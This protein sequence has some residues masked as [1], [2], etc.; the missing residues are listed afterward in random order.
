MGAD[1]T[2]G[3]IIKAKDFASAELGKL[4]GELGKVEDKSKGAGKGLAGLSP[5]AAGVVAGGVTLLVGGLLK[6]GQ[7]AVDEQVNIAKLD[8]A[9]KTNVKGWKGNTDA[10]EAQIS[11][12]E[13]LAFSDDELRS[14]LAK[15]VTI[16]GDV[17]RAQEMQALAMDL[18]RA[19]GIDLATATDAIGK[20]SQGSTRP[21][22][23]LG[24]EIDDSRTAAENLAALQEKVAGQAGAYA[25]TTKGKFEALQV[26]LDDTVENIGTALLPV[27]EKLADFMLDSVVP[28]IDAIVS[29]LGEMGKA[30][31]FWFPS[32]NTRTVGGSLK[33]AMS[34]GRQIAGTGKDDVVTRAA[35]GPVRAGQLALVGER[36]PELVRFGAAG[37]VLSADRTARLAAGA[38]GMPDAGGSAAPV[39]LAIQLDGRTIATVVD[40]HL[41]YRL[42]AAGTGS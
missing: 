29:G 36:G 2:L 35:G 33:Q 21:L 18:A 7:A 11:Q 25:S 1:S 19:K 38:P 23:D 34:I 26:K 17:T 14:S 15:F 3:I 22:K 9:L 27:F 32:T 37:T 6:A 40:E 28:A 4:S 16:T 31:S 39:Q 24:V 13:R 12:R 5:I 10:I 8:Q 20:A 30:I 42:R 41:Y